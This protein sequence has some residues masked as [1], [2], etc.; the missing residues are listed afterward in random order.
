MR[1]VGIDDCRLMI[2]LTDVDSQI[3]HDP[4]LTDYLQDEPSHSS[5][6][7]PPWTDREVRRLNIQLIREQPHEVRR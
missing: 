3:Q 6:T 2:V 5:G 4:P 1:T 7:Q